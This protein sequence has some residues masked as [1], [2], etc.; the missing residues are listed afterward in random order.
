MTNP[1]WKKISAGHYSTVDGD[2]EVKRV[3]SLQT[4][5]RTEVVWEIV[6]R[7]RQTLPMCQDSLRDAKQVV[8]GY[9]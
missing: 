2:F 6:V 9:Y 1:R 8:G 7:G 5:H 3:K 4:G